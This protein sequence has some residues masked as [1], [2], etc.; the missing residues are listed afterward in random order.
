MKPASPRK[1]FTPS[2]LKGQKGV[3]VF[4]YGST[5]YK[6]EKDLSDGLFVTKSTHHPNYAT[7]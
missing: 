1:Y 4:A 3:H 6:T 2:A 7:T 5:G